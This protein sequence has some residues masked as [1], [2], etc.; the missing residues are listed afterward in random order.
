MTAIPQSITRAYRLDV[1]ER[2]DGFGGSDDAWLRVGSLLEH[3]AAAA[4]HDASAAAA[5]SQA[6]CSA[7]AGAISHERLATFRKHECANREPS[8]FDAVLVL[9]DDAHDAGAPHAAASLLDGIVACGSELHPLTLGRV[10]ARRARVALRSGWMSSAQDRAADLLALGERE[11][12]PELIGRAWIAFTALAQMR[13]NYPEMERGARE[14]EQVANRLSSRYFL[15]SARRSL[16]VVAGVRQDF[17]R[18]LHYAWLVYQDC[19]GDLGE[20]AHTLQ[21]LGQLF[22]E[23]GYPD[24][25][26]A[27]FARVISQPLP[28]RFL[29]PALGG[30]AMASARTGR[31][32]TVA[33]AAA[34][35]RALDVEVAPK[36]QL[37]YALVEC[38]S[39]CEAVGR[40]SEAEEALARATELAETF[41]FHEIAFRAAERLAPAAPLDAPARAVAREIASLEPAQLPEHLELAGVG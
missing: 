22:L 33:W 36:Y 27:A 2:L 34:Q 20:E 17:D 9:S 6:A 26:R 29:L 12:E 11:R 37:A 28:V 4:R 10:M 14:V 3:A 41:K 15:R 38:A 13:G 18:A 31:A 21:N 8:P 7:A 30:L 35:A 39:A 5:M 23:A 24:A 25:A 16:T 1:G 19:L 40:A 32:E